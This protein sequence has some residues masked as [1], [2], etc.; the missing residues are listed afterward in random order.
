VL[1]LY[2]LALKV[3]GSR[4]AGVAAVWIAGLGLPMPMYY[5]NWGRYTQLSGQVILVTAVVL[6]WMLL[7]SRTSGSSE[8]T[9]RVA[10]V[11]GPAWKDRAR[12]LPSALGAYLPA[13]VAIAGLALTHYRVLV[14]YGAFV[15]AWLAIDA[16]RGWRRA[17][18]L[19]AGSLVIVAP[20]L[21]RALGGKIVDI[22]ASQLTTAPDR[23]SSFSVQYNAIG[24]LSTYMPLVA[25]LL[26]PLAA[27]LGL[28]RRRRGVGL[29]SLWWFLLFVATN[30]QIL[31]LPGSGVITNFALFI[32]V[33]IPAGLL[34]GDLCGWLVALV[35]SR[36][37]MRVLLALLIVGGG[38]AGARQRIGDM[39]IEQHALAL[40]PDVEAMAWIREN[41][42]P[43]ARFLV[44]SFFAYGG[45]VIVG[46]DGGWWMPLLAG[47]ANTV[48]PLNYSAEQGPW[49]EYRLWVN[50]LT[51]IIQD[52]GVADPAT[53]DELHRR[54]ITHVYVGQ[55]Q[56]RVNYGG[57]YVLSPDVLRQSPYYRPI[58]HRDQV[59]VFEL[60]QR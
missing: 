36:A 53:V 17:L 46:S 35:G 47:R 12:R 29:V 45:S 37:W 24:N 6:T 13:W 52:R 43:E 8:G 26:L 14:F 42:P 41:T 15:A 16:G 40:Q 27:A 39:R 58:Y 4:W 7:E 31:R 56:G 10:R 22:V 2:P 23:L 33:Y 1:G 51:T 49:P 55:R 59:W 54:G 5:V 38:L 20:W 11:R 30:P 60:V 57:P 34:I 9:G 50:E 48:P 32:A 28:W 19:G 44:N 18:G 3:S 25:W 21:V